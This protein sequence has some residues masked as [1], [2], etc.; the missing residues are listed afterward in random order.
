MTDLLSSK[1]I[2]AVAPEVADEIKAA[3]A[4]KYEAWTPQVDPDIVRLAIDEALDQLFSQDA[5][6]RSKRTF[7]AIAAG[8]AALFMLPEVQGLLTVIL[9]AGFVKSAPVFLAASSAYLVAWSKLTDRRMVK[10]TCRL[11]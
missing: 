5:P 6:I 9:P 10:R 3:V 4:K 8:I 1:V 11:K 2:R 7:G